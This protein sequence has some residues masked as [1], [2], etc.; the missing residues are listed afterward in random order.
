MVTEIEMPSLSSLYGRAALGAAR[1]KL[2]PGAGAR[3][4]PGRSVLAQHPGVSV[5]QAESYRRLFGGESFDGAHRAALPSVL[6]HIIGF[7]MQMALMSDGEFPLPLMGLVHVANEVEHLRPVRV[8]QPVQILVAAENLRP[9]RRGTQVDIKVTVLEQGADPANA[10]SENAA[11]TSVLWRS[12]STYLSKG[13]QLGTEISA[14]SG[15]TDVTR[16]DAELKSFVPPVKTASWRLGSE[17][18]R[19]YAAVSGD[20]NPIH[21]SQLAAKALGMPAAI[22]HG[23]YCAGR[24]LEGR[25]PEGAGHRWW[26]RFEAPVTLPG[27]VAFAA[28]PHGPKAVRFIGWNP[29]KARRH[30]S[31]ELQL[32]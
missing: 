29:R 16:S 18:G 25:E 22:V 28:E 13:T 23:M 27:T 10:D 20:Y 2:R 15:S 11:E 17:A 5:E 32:P 26:I 31:A 19:A 8:G 3:T 4:L 12:V 1:S 14:D 21:V 7:P 9:H 6:V 24:M 30:F